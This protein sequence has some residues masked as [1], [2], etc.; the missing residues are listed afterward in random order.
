MKRFASVT[1]DGVLAACERHGAARTLRSAGA[2]V[3]S[4]NAGVGRTYATVVLDAAADTA[5]VAT[6]SAARVD[7]PPLVVLHVT[8]R[9]A[10]RVA[11]IAE[12]L[13]GP[14]RPDGVRDMR[15]DGEVLVVEVDAR[16]T[17]L[18]VVLALVDLE[19]GGAA[20]RRVEPLVALDDATLAAL[21]G[22]ALREPDLDATRLIETYL[23]PLLAQ[24]SA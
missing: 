14:G 7:E 15:H 16:R 21:A 17:S 13:G 12:A 9:F 20:L 4:W 11:C 22:A 18:A 24:G 5:A 8:P 1:F 10:D 2:T 19:A 3:T 6:A 23:E